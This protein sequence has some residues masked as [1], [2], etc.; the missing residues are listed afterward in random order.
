MDKLNE[1]LLF[2]ALATISGALNEIVKDEGTK[3]LLNQSRTAC[4][5]ASFELK[6]KHKKENHGTGKNI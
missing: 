6:T 2:T 5:L 1:M 3:E 4:A